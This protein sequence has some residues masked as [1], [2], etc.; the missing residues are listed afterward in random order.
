VPKDLDNKAKDMIRGMESL[1][2]EDPR[3]RLS[4]R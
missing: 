2:K 4:H 1:Y 3:R